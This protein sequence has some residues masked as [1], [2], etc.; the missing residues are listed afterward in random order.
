MMTM[1]NSPIPVGARLP[2]PNEA[3]GPEGLL[4]IATAAAELGFSSVWASD[5]IILPSEIESTYPFAKEAVGDKG[6]VHPI[7]FG[8]DS[9]WLD[10]LLTLSWLAGRLPEGIKLGTSVIIVS[11]RNP[12]LLAKQIG[13]LS[14]L[15]RSDLYLGVG[16][17][18]LKEEYDFVGIPFTKKGTRAKGVIKRTRELLEQESVP[19]HDDSGR[20]TTV[21]PRPASNVRFL[22][23]GYSDF[24]LR[25]V[26]EV[27]HGWFPTKLTFDGL[28]ECN[29]QLKRYCDEAGTDYDSLKKII[30]PGRGPYPEMGAVNAENLERYAAVGMQEAVVELP[31]EPA[32]PDECIDILE[33]IAKKVEK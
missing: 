24:A 12:V 18:W 27:C 14:W 16:S 28:A 8:V 4:A 25:A 9:V 19:L 22:Y 13:T 20:T 33:D 1:L 26:A 10:P 30:K 5:H 11:L 31:L 21:R 23:G 15:T 3:F 17:G 32:S 6:N 7:A 2:L 29:E